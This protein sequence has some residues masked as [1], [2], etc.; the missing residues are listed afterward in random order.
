MSSSKLEALYE[1]EA[2]R[3]VRLAFLMTGDKELAEDIV[4]DAF[5]KVAGRFQHLRKPHAS[6]AYLR[7]TIINLSKSHWRRGGVE[8]R[9]LK[10][11]SPDLEVTD[12]ELPSQKIMG[13]LRTLP[14]RQRAAV[15]LRYYED[16]SEAATAQTLGCSIGAVKQLTHR[17]KEQLRQMLREEVEG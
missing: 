15:V 13:A 9:Y 11:L 5:V 17:A 2:Q 6:S 10:Q 4:Q 12:P 7:R 1:Q 16:F 3:S 14:T 8:K